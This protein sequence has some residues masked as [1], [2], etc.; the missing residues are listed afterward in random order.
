VSTSIYGGLIYFVICLLLFLFVQRWLHHELQ[1]ILLLLTRKPQLT[2]GLFSLL[3]FPGVLLHESSHFI[4]AII[5]RVKTRRF[6][7]IPR[8]LPGGNVRMGYVETALTD[9]V[10]DALIGVAPLVSGLAVTAAL[11]ATR[12]GLLPLAGLAF[13]GQWN[14]LLGALWS[15]PRLQDFWLWFYFAFTISSTMLPSA[16]DRRAW[17]PVMIII[18]AVILIALL[19]GAGAWMLKNIAPVIN[20]GLNMLAMIFAISL[21]I[22]LILGIPAWL[23]RALIS[24]L[25][26]L[27]VA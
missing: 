10:R 7:V 22:H 27:R 13:E 18:G 8:V 25:V 3:F 12:L 5:L 26:G 15:I 11:G 16:A 20:R 9:P 2:I 14:E 24:R 1:A 21:A 4:A 17:L 23:S 6:S 19:A